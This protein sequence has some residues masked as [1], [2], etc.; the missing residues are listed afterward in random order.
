MILLINKPKG[1]TSFDVIR[2]LRRKL[3]IK[4]MGHAG[5]LDPAA[6]GLIIIATE[7]DTKKLTK[8]LKLDKE[9]EAEIT[10]GKISNTYDMEGEVEDAGF[11]GARPSRAEIEEALKDFVGDIEQMPP[12]FSAKKIKGVP[13]YKLARKG[14]EV[15]LEPKTVHIEKIDILSYEWPKLNVRITCGSGT[16][17][18]SIAHDIG[19]KFGCGGLLS[20]LVRTRVGDFN[21][22]DARD[23]S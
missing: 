17:V 7:G 3:G 16:Y 18:R 14:K 22:E 15:K 5:T 13:A 6:T 12:A 20:A 23:L 10:F 4:K 11:D 1:I 9:Y 21:L 2:K 19:E 8:F